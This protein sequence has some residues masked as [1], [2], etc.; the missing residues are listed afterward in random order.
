MKSN[1]SNSRH[2]LATRAITEIESR[3]H[4]E[5]NTVTNTI[6]ET[7][8]VYLALLRGFNSKIWTKKFTNTMG[9]LTQ[10]GGTRIPTGNNTVFFIIFLLKQKKATY[11][12]VVAEI[13]PHKEETRHV[14]LTVGGYRLDFDG[15]TANQ[16]ASLPTTQTLMNST[17]STHGATFMTMDL[18]D[19]Y[20][21]KPME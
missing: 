20:Y 1:P 2:T 16:F 18:K 19:F 12:Q 8:D 15:V 4:Y 5:T 6:T 7:D 17:I 3:G 21:G 14:C 9:R 11:G 10:G 13:D